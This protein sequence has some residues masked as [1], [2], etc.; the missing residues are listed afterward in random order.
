MSGKA[1]QWKPGR[2]AWGVV[3]AGKLEFLLQINGEAQGRD[4]AGD[5]SRPA[6]CHD[7]VETMTVEEDLPK[8]P[9]FAHSGS[10][11]HHT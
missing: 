3:V 4:S 2:H 11:E 1:A 8:I 10:C 7:L 6:P 5:T 9:G